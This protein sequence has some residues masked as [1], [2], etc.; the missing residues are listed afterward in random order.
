MGKCSYY[1]LKTN[2]LSIEAE[3]VACPGTISAALGITSSAATTMPSCTKS[4][5]ISYLF[6]GRPVTIKLNQGKQVLIDGL[7]VEKLPWNLF[8]GHIRIREPSS[9]LTSVEFY[10]GLKIVWDGMTRVYIDA[11]SSYRGRTQGLCGTFNSNLLDDFLTPEGDV[12]STVE[13]FADKWRTKESCQFVA[14]SP[15]VP[16]PCQLNVENRDK[17]EQVCSK[18][19]SN[20]FDD[21][22][23]LVDPMSY[24]Y[25]CLYDMCACKGDASQCMCPIL[26]A[27]AAECARQGAIVNWRYSVPECC[28][29]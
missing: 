2:N 10:D 5:T 20:I 26:A 15:S 29:F 28:K 11:P 24:Y 14:D 23:W 1:L 4:V 25:D 21:C 19:T 7:E 27:Y 22:H 16:H 18:I 8:D 6:N 17:A 13:N 9:L 12:E 3:N